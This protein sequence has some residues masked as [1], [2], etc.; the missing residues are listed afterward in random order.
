[1]RRYAWLL[2]LLAGCTWLRGSDG[3]RCPAHRTP[4]VGLPEDVTALAGC[5]RVSGLTI[6]TG[7][8]LDLA[9]LR[10]LAEIDGD[11]VVGPT[12]GVE[13]VALNGLVRVGGAIRI[14]DNGSLRGVFLPRLEEAG[15]VDVEGNASLTSIAMPR[16]TQVQGGLVVTGNQALAL[17]D[18]PVLTRVGG[19]LLIAGSPRLTLLQLPALTAAATVRIEGAVKVPP[20][21]LQALARAA[22]TP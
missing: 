12:V 5:E 20:E 15:R 2:V 7:A 14:A 6:R 16:L 9:P 21:V 8:S 10:E 22:A 17:V 4:V 3:S 1:M 11:L 13:E 18:A 19:D